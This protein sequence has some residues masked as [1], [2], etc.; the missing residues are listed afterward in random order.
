M[1]NTRTFCFQDHGLE[2]LAEHSRMDTAADNGSMMMTG[3]SS[4]MADNMTHWEPQH[5]ERVVAIVV[6]IIFGMI[7]VL[8]FVGNMLVIIVVISNKQMRNTTNLLI[9]NLAVADLLFI[10]ICVPFT[11]TIYAMSWWPFGNIFCK[12]YQYVIH[13]TA[14]ASVYTLVLM[15]LD[16]YLAVV[17]PICSMTIRTERNAYY[18]IGLSWIVIMTLNI[19]VFLDY[20]LHEYRFGAENRSTCLNPKVMND[21]RQGQIFYGCF[22]V[23]SYVLPLT[24]VC[25]LY[26]FM[27][28]RLL[29]GGVPGLNQ[30]AESMRG[31]KRVTRMVVMVVVIFALCWL[32]IHIILMINYFGKYPDTAAFVCL[33]IASNCIA[34]MNSCVNPL[35]YAFLSDNFRKSF[36]KLLCC[37]NSFQ[38]VK[39]E[40]E[41]TNARGLDA[42]SKTT[43]TTPLKYNGDNHNHN[44]DDNENCV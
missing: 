9:I 42:M 25:I 26:G 6:P 43:C 15:S 40:Y 27:L 10:V 4:D 24:A 23:F 39:L 17:H 20:E 41:R 21:P 13:V 38:P 12:I 8:G 11:G 33:Q 16:R 37:Y 36:R 22:F 30:S 7:A 34:Y 31:K 29:Y 28:R 19:P 18:M 44:A 1:I 5:I 2:Q 35:L 14:Y 32:P 3:N